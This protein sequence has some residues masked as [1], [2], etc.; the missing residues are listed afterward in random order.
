MG[1]TRGMGKRMDGW[2]EEILGMMFQEVSEPF[3]PS[4]LG[5]YASGTGIGVES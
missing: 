3:F 1:V 5:L 2:L 4:S